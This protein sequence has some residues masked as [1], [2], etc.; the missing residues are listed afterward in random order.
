MTIVAP[1]VFPSGDISSYLAK[2]P[3]QHRRA[4]KYVAMLSV[5]L[6]GLEDAR[7][8]AQSLPAVFDLDV[9]IGAQLDICGLWIGRSRVLE[10]AIS[11]TYFSWDTPDFGWDQGIWYVIGDPLTTVVILP[12]QQ[13]RLLLKFQASANH[14][15]GTFDGAY[16]IWEQFLTPVGFHIEITDNQD[17]TMELTAV[18]S[19]PD[20]LTKQMFINGYFDLRPSGVNITAHNV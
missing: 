4:P 1:T 6:Q 8:V 17:M 11:T 20:D 19:I 13:Y 14:W 3:S 18:G 7:V 16:A 12:D 15:D 5:I 10:A 2:I 9:A